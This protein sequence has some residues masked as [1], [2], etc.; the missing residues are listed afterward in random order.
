MK[1]QFVFNDEKALKLGYTAQSC[2]DAVDKLFARYGITPT[3]QGV[4][5]GP[6][7]QNT[8]TAFGMA[9]KLP[10]TDWFLR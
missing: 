9:H 10:Y 5:E 1:M 3:T 4:Y 7:N 8:F 2:Y 6:Y